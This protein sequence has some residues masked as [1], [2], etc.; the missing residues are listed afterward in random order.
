MAKYKKPTDPRKAMKSASDST[1]AKPKFE[2]P[3][4]M[5]KKKEEEKRKAL[6]RAKARAAARRNG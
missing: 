1:T 4:D 5:A 6:E 3:F 2:G